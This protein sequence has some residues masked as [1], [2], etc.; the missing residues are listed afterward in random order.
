MVKI[1]DT[2][3]MAIL[4]KEY[5]DITIGRITMKLAFNIDG[6]IATELD[7]ST[8]NGCKPCSSSESTGFV[9]GLR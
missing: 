7:I 5:I 2:N 9:P 6:S 1:I 8:T 4:G 3:T